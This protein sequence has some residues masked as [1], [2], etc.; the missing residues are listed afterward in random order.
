MLYAFLIYFCAN[1]G[2]IKS[3]QSNV[4]VG[5]DYRLLLIDFGVA[6]VERIQT[7][8]MTA[9]EP[10]GSFRWMAPE[11]L[12][13]AED[14]KGPILSTKTDVYAF[15]MTCIEVRSPTAFG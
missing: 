12:M 1:A 15:A 13:T 2:L 14:G 4:V 3:S 7:I 10:Q 5:E 11:L 9:G 6:K 8:I